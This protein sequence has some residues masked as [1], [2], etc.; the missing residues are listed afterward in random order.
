MNIPEFDEII[1]PNDQTKARA[2]HLE[3]LSELVGNVYPNRFVRSSL[4]GS[5]D[6]ITNILKFEP[7]A[8]IVNKRRYCRSRTRNTAAGRNKGRTERAA[9]RIRQ[10]SYRGPADHTATREFCSPHRRNV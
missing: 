7:V 8:A 6:T 2:E 1:E 4:S 9:Q 10:C 3:E 5:E